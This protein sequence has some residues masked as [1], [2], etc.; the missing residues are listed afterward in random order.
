[1]IGVLFWAGVVM[2]F[3]GVFLWNGIAIASLTRD[4]NW[5]D[6]FSL[7]SP[8]LVMRFQLR[9]D[10]A[11][12]ELARRTG[13]LRVVQ[14]LLAIAVACL[15]AAGIAQVISLIVAKQGGAA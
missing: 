12:S 14:L 11:A 9:N 2:A 7:I 1:M 4:P 15:M 13:L 10:Q 6:A 5:K 3:A 8:S